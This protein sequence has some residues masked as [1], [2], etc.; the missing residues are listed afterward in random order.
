MIVNPQRVGIL[1]ITA[2]V[3][4]GIAP[5]QTK[6]ITWGRAFRYSIFSS[7]DMELFLFH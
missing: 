2:F 4:N 3:L 5:Q 1:R 7:F 6:Y